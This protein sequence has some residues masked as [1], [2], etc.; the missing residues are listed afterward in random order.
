MWLKLLAGGRKSG[1]PEDRV[2]NPIAP[3]PLITQAPGL[4]TSR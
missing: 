3:E 2:A 4:R 1:P